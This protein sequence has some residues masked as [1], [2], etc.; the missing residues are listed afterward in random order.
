[1]SALFFGSFAV[2]D[3]PQIDLDPV[4]SAISVGLEPGIGVY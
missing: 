2:A 3:V 1:L 4:S